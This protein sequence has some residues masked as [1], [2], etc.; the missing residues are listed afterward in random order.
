MA[1]LDNTWNGQR[2]ARRILW[3]EEEEEEEEKSASACKAYDGLNL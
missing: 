2:N 3:N 1:I